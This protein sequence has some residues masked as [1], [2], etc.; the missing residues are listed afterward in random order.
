MYPGQPCAAIG[1]KCN[2]P[3][4][5]ES[6]EVLIGLEESAHAESIDEPEEKQQPENVAD[7]GSCDLRVNF[8]PRGCFMLVFSF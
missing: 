7:L 8:M 2:A 3:C 5:L 4:R 6:L 1:P